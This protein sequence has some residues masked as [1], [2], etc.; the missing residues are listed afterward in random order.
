MKQL[1]L[2]T[3]EEIG[4]T[5]GDIIITKIT[6]KP[7]AILGLATGSSP[8]S[9]YKYLVERTKKNNIDWSNITT[10][11]LDEYK[12]LSSDHEQSYRYFMNEN[13]FKHVNIKMEQTHVPSGLINS[14]SEAATY[15]QE[16]QEAGGIDL[17]ILGLG[18]NGHIG[19][20]EPGTSF[21]SITSVVD[22]QKSTI[23]ANS[24]FFENIEE[25]PTQAISMGLKTIMKAKEILLIAT[26]SSKANAVK[27]L[28]EGPV[29]TEWPCSILQQHPN[30]TL[31]LDEDSASL[32]SK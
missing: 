27:H 20:N 30:V 25:V 28:V 1:I 32:L 24:R 13:L 19:F 10:F 29:T 5:A 11:N 8:L 4:K 18:I 9:T 3:T 2:K 7:D 15:D 26:G 12:G 22:L 31:L 23:E 16:I 14:N 17:Q 6:K 21:D